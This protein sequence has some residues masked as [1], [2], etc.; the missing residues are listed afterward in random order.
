MEPFELL[1]IR[2]R[3]SL[4]YT[5]CFHM[6]LYNI[7]KYTIKIGNITQVTLFRNVT[8]YLSNKV[9]VGSVISR[10]MV[11]RREAKKLQSACP[12]KRRMTTTVSYLRV[13][14]VSQY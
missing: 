2:P 8:R 6:M 14:T 1:W 12:I 4:R 7:M 10:L 9:T 3:F 11:V 13:G 5:G